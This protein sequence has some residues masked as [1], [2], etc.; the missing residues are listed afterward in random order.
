KR[1]EKRKGGRR[2]EV[3]FAI[4]SP[5]VFLLPSLFS[6]KLYL[7]LPL[8]DV[9][10]ISAKAS[11]ATETVQRLSVEEILSFAHEKRHCSL[12]N[13]VARMT[14]KSMMRWR[15]EKEQKTETEPK[16]KKRKK[17]MTMMQKNEEDE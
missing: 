13:H 11:L 6:L 8:E 16:E 12:R 4:L 1:N 9:F 10:L 14:M 3:C 7:L 2:N 17:M 5:V 15:E